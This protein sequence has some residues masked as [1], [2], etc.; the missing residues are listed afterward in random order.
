MADLFFATN[1]NT[2][3]SSIN[4][5]SYGVES[6]WRRYRDVPFISVMPLEALKCHIDRNEDQNLCLTVAR[7]VC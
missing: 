3:H 5:Q 1:E 4:S 7:F 6:F 2:C